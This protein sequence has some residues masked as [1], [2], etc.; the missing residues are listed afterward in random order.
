MLTAFTCMSELV[1]PP[2]AAGWLQSATF[3][4]QR[5]VRRS[6][7]VRL[8]RAMTAGRFRETTTVEF[9]VTPDGKRFLV[10]GQHTLN[11]VVEAGAT[12]RLIIVNTP[13]ADL[14][15]VKALYTTFD[16]GLSRTFTNSYAAMGLNEKFDMTDTEVN[17][18]GRAVPFIAGAFGFRSTREAL[19]RQKSATNGLRQWFVY[20][21]AARRFLDCLAPSEPMVRRALLQ[22]AVFALGVYTIAHNPEKAELFWSAAA[23]D[24]KLAKVD[25]PKAATVLAQRPSGRGT[26]K[27]QVALAQAIALAWNAYVLGRIVKTASI[28]K[29][30]TDAVRILGTPLAEDEAGNG[31]AHG[32]TDHEN[33]DADETADLHGAIENLTRAFPPAPEAPHHDQPI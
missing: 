20:H 11:A 9:A 23:A 15:A 14:D 12:I 1:S 31:A 10:N 32:A 24:E 17:A 3:D 30:P 33:N 28:S 7:A 13:V 16:N 27:A 2:I 4:G 26:M 29:A 21:V 6:H 22:P 5:Q 19:A 18:Y 25:P 8:A